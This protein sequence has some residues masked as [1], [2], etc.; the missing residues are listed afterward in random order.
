MVKIRSF[1]GYL[2]K[3]DECDKVIAPAYEKLNAEEA[4]QTAEENPM[5]FLNINKIEAELAADQIPHN[6]TAVQEVA[7]DALPHFIEEGW[8]V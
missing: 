6:T 3:K 5:S 7:Q 1:R 2:A 4:R 8:L